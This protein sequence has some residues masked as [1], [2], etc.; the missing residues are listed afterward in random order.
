MLFR[1]CLVWVPDWSL[2]IVGGRSG[3]LLY[4]MAPDV[5]NDNGNPIRLEKRTGFIDYGARKD[6]RSEEIR[7]RAK[8]G[9]GGISRDPKLMF[10][11]NTDNKGWNSF[12][13]LSLGQEG[14]SEIVMSLKR[15]GIFK[16]RQ[17]EIVVTDDVPVAFGD[18][19]EDI[20]I[21]R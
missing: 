15:T 2:H 21:L 18:G 6:K 20:T 17:Y 4:K 16:A 10:R 11:W 7:F 9:I 19:E 5:Y 1:S 13:E 3:G 14:E 12:K 8:R